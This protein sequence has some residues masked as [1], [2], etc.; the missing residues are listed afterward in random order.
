MNEFE[1]YRDAIAMLLN[2]DPANIT[3]AR[4]HAEKDVWM[5]VVL[6]NG[7]VH[8]DL[9]GKTVR[10]CYKWIH[11]KGNRRWHNGTNAR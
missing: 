7:L 2:T 8:I 10:L 4:W 3:K 5:V 1:M 6:D 9:A 11:K